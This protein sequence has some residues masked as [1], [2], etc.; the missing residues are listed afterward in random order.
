MLSR[1]QRVIFEVIQWKLDSGEPGFIFIDVPGGIGKTFLLNVLLSYGRQSRYV[2]IATASCGIAATLLKL[3]R[4]AHSRFKFSIP[5]TASS[6]C[7]ISPVDST[8]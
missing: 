8:G 5:V 7:N 6:T 2:A 1:D 4:T 3:G